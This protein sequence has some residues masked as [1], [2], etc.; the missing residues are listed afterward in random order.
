MTYVERWTLTFPNG[1]VYIGESATDVLRKLRK[2]Q[3]SP[4]AR[5]R[6]KRALAWR[7]WVIDRTAVDEDL[8]DAEFLL[9]LNASAMVD[10]AIEYPGLEDG[11]D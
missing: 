3:W 9:A 10:V 8:N 5:R 11:D 7:A 4:E 1:A 2:D 6:V